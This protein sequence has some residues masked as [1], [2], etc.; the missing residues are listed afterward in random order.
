LRVTHGLMFRVLLQSQRGRR[1]AVSNASPVVLKGWVD[2][3]AEDGTHTR[4][5]AGDSV[6]IPGGVRHNVS[7]T[8]N[9]I[10]RPLS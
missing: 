4:I 7:G 5:E 10:S 6:R 8:A 1:V 2:L 9:E 3:G